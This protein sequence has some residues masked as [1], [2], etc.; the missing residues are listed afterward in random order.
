MY[1]IDGVCTL[2]NGKPTL[3]HWVVK[4]GRN[5]NAKSILTKFDGYFNGAVNAFSAPKAYAL[6]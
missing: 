1:C 3:I 4:Q 2:K 6:A 5:K